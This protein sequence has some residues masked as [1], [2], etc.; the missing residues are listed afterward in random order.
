MEIEHESRWR[1]GR[2]GTLN[3]ET[4][5]QQLIEEYIKLAFS[6]EECMPGYVDSYFGPEELKAH[7]KQDGKIP[8]QSLTER[9][10]RLASDILQ[11]D[12]D[13]QFPL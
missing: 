12:M 13:A 4:S 3:M 6:I 9:T 11:A 5:N 7:A 8:L 10:A 2:R 1:R